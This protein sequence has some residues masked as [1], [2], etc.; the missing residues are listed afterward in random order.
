MTGGTV[1]VLGATGRNFA[2][3]MSGGIAYVYDETGDF[4]SRCNPSMVAL[5]P[6]LAAQEQAA[7]VDTVLW[8]SI[9][10]GPSADEAI[11]RELIERQFRHTGSFRAKEILHDWDRMRSRFVKVFPN[12][13]RR[14]LKQLAEARKPA[15]SAA[16]AAEKLAA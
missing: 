5:E 3:G 4:A 9:G 11:V 6:V 13:Y 14:A 8:H 12:E 7:R 1:V 15:A 16:A 10:Q 2:A